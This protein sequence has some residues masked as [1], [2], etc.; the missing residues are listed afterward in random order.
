MGRYRQATYHFHEIAR[1]LSNPSR[2]YGGSTMGVQSP[3]T[4]ATHVY[5]HEHK[6]SPIIQTS[7]LKVPIYFPNY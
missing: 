6:G 2:H 1:V 5:A 7:K 4:L 3:S